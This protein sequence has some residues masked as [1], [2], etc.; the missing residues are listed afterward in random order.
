[1][2]TNV[3]STA[4][5]AMTAFSKSPFTYI[6]LVN[7]EKKTFSELLEQVGVTELTITDFYTG[8]SCD[9]RPAFCK[10]VPIKD[11][12]FADTNSYNL[13]YNIR[14]YG[15]RAYQVVPITKKVYQVNGSTIE[16]FSTN[17]F[18][19]C[20]KSTAICRATNAA[21]E[22]E[23]NTVFSGVKPIENYIVSAKEKHGD[24]PTSVL[25]EIASADMKADL[26]SSK[27]SIM[28]AAKAKAASKSKPKAA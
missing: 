2:K 27:K 9:A 13:V 7:K 18:V 16:A 5:K 10:L 20:L 24:L 12:Y 22:K 28:A 17:D 21:T 8:E 11:S 25:E 4:K 23:L 14:Y 3:F 19:D 26:N 6:N 15:G 1:M